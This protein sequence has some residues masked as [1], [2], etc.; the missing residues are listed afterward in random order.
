[1]TAGRPLVYPSVDVALEAYLRDRGYRV[2]RP[3]PSVLADK[4]AYTII[5][6]T[7][8][9]DP[10]ELARFVSER[11]LRARLRGL[12]EDRK[13]GLNPASWDGCVVKKLDGIVLGVVRGEDWR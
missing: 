8:A 11:E 3:D 9:D 5:V 7:G 2:K 1:M 12:A 4:G 6:F 10:V 13:A